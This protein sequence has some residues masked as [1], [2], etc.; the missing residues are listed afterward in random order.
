MTKMSMAQAVEML[1]GM[2][3]DEDAVQIDDGAQMWNASALVDETREHDDG[4]IY[5]LAVNDGGIVRI[6]PDGYL[7]STHLYQVRP[8]P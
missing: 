1:R 5:D 6:R 2:I 4:T 7:E 3:P 8:R